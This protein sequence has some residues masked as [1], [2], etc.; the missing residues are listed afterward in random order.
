MSFEVYDGNS[1]IPM[2]K[3]E[4]GGGG[5][6][7]ADGVIYQFIGSVDTLAELEALDTSAMKPGYVYD[8]KE[9]GKNYALTEDGDWD[10]LGGKFDGLATKDELNAKQDLLHPKQPLEISVDVIE[11]KT[12]D[13]ITYSVANNGQITNTFPTGGSSLN[14]GWIDFY[15]PDG[16]NINA[17]TDYWR[18]GSTAGIKSIVKGNQNFEIFKVY[19]EE[20]EVARLWHGSGGYRIGA[21]S[22]YGS[23]FSSQTATGVVEHEAGS[24]TTQIVGDR[25]HKNT[26]KGMTITSSRLSRIRFH[27]YQ[28]T[29]QYNNW[30]T[31]T[32]LYSEK[33]GT[34]TRHLPDIRL[35]T[36]AEDTEG[37]MLVGTTTT[38]YLKV[39]TGDGLTVQNNKLIADTTKVADVDFSNATDVAKIMM[40]NASMPST[41]K[42]VDL[43]LLASGSTY[44]APADGFIQ[45]RMVATGN[46]NCGFSLYSPGQNLGHNEEVFQV[47]AHIGT[48][49]E[50]QK[51]QTYSIDYWNA[52]G[53]LFRFIYAKGSESEAQ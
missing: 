43:T 19:S 7:G 15:V 8:V 21:S 46:N 28:E 33:T 42:Y 53:E 40:A 45:L 16:I 48:Y 49:L 30:G 35:Y 51:G 23:G 11:P 38:E 2:G 37:I 26:S 24:T 34:K 9:N 18:F 52:T 39:N 22:S 5:G 36:S 50:V 41:T 20:G 27:Q 44:T 13:N 10:D 3:A 1:G 6:G 29:T 4:I 47:G 14:S 25:E 12:S 31:G 32:C 17:L